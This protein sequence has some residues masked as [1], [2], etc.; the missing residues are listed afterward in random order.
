MSSEPIIT[1][2]GL[3]KCYQIYDSPAER[4]KQMLYPRAAKLLRRTVNPRFKEFW[5]LRGVDF[6]IHRGEA[7]GILGRN[8]SGKTTLLQVLCGT[9]PHN[10]G[11]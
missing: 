10:E 3:G 11:Y 4:L 6:R 9:L 1:A 5:A 7:V 8:G 2:E